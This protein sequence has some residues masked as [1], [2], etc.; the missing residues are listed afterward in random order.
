MWRCFEFRWLQRGA[1]GGI[2]YI[3][4]RQISHLIFI[5]FTWSRVTCGNCSPADSCRLRGKEFP[6]PHHLIGSSTSLSLSSLYLVNT[7][8]MS[9]ALW[10]FL[11]YRFADFTY[12]NMGQ[13]DACATPSTQS[14]PLRS[15][16]WD[17]EMKVLDADFGVRYFMSHTTWAWLV[18]IFVWF[19][20]EASRRA[21]I[22]SFFLH[23]ISPSPDSGL[24][25]HQRR[26]IILSLFLLCGPLITL[27]IRFRGP[28]LSTLYSM[29]SL[30]DTLGWNWA[31]DRPYTS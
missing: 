5:S 18:W 9:L 28:N 23:R 25:W 17:S 22:R 27:R 4:A 8:T 11:M 2:G 21:S 6:L 29:I 10:I 13:S 19:S 14:L 20:Y 16:W 30:Q 12:C 1:N 24:Q 3:A 31:H 26:T 7:Q 15:Q